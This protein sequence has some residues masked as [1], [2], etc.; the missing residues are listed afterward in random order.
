MAL[1]TAQPIQITGTAITLSAPAA[2]APGSDTV[3]PGERTFWWV[4][5]GGTAITATVVTPGSRFGQALPD[6]AV[7]CP[8]TGD[9]FIGPLTGD[10]AD[11]TTGLVT[12]Q[13][14]AQTSVTH[15]VVVI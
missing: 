15:A 5:T 1:L 3:A 14:S 8:A 6:V 2:G 10:L 13:T 7:S 4:K 11:P 9:R 12:L